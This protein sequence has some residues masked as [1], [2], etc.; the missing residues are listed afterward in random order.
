MQKTK[1]ISLLNYAENEPMEI[2]IS[3]ELNLSVRPTATIEISKEKGE[4]GAFYRC[5]IAFWGK[6]GDHLS[7][8]VFSESMRFRNPTFQISFV[9]L[10]VDE[11]THPLSEL[12]NVHMIA[13]TLAQTGKLI[14]EDDRNGS[15]YSLTLESVILGDGAI[16]DHLSEEFAASILETAE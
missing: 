4:G 5:T 11:L 16:T 15:G 14:L 13:A 2:Q 10:S 1:V 3:S 6:D 8:H 12:S 7:S 9:G